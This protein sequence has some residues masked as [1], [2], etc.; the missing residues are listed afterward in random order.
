MEKWHILIV[1]NTAPFNLED[2]SKSRVDFF[3]WKNIDE[4]NFED[5]D[6]LFLNFVEHLHLGDVNIECL[7]P[8]INWRL[9]QTFFIFA[10]RTETNFRTSLKSS[11]TWNFISSIWPELP[12]SLD[13]KGQKI[14]LKA[15]KEKITSLILDSS[16]SFNWDWG[17]NRKKLPDNVYV[18][19]ENNI[20]NIVSLIL[21][22]GKKNLIFIPHPDDF[23]YYII[24]S[25]QTLETII[26]ELTQLE[27]YLV[28]KK[29]NWLKDYDL[30]H[31]ENLLNK[32]ALY[33]KE[34][35]QIE[36][37]EILL[38]GYDK[39]LEKTVADIFLFLGFQN[40]QRSLTSA[41]LICESTTSKIIAEIKGLKK[42]A[43]ENNVNQMFKWIA[44]EKEKELESKKKIKQIFVCNAFREKVPTKRGL[45][46]HERVIELAKVHHWG[47]LSTLNLYHALLKIH[48]KELRKEDVMSAIENQEGIIEF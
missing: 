29:P 19:A 23:N 6:V 47:L 12:S 18:L 40:I 44:E 3:K 31:K 26:N 35:K 13:T 25:I 21:K 16:F 7:S 10:S 27:Q 4:C 48:E 11:R 32:I 2:F 17:I 46:F 43:T 39:P 14:I 42:K 36:K 30:F 38:Y 1:T 45:F 8:L 28:L 22:K 41:D 15:P 34:V 33:K 9:K 20:G 37:Y 5:Y 24:K